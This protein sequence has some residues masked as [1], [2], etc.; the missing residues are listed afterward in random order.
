MLY[1]TWMVVSVLCVLLGAGILVGPASTSDAWLFIGGAM[2]SLGIVLG[3]SSFRAWLYWR[4]YYGKPQAKDDPEA[5]NDLKSP[6][7]IGL[8]AL[9]PSRD[10]APQERR[11]SQRIMVQIPVLLWI[12]TPDQERA[13][14]LGF[15]SWVNAHGGI[16]ESPVRIRAGQKVTLLIPK[17]KKEAGGRVVQVQKASDESFATSFE[18]DRPSPEFWPIASRPLDW[19]MV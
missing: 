7:V 10:R 12:E 9:K 1:Q 11:R 14:A 18:F 13:P 19:G 4:K 3:A 15:T 6:A 5:V 2:V 17:S 16:L 8:P